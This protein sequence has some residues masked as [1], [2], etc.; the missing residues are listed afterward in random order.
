MS[1]GWR[2]GAAR[3][4]AI[5]GAL[6]AA[7]GCAGAGDGGPAA[8]PVSLREVDRA[9]YDA[10]LAE[11]R[12]QVVL[13]D[14]WA[15]WCAPC[16]TQLT[17]TLQLAERHKARGLAVITLSMDEAEAQPR[18]QK[19]LTDRASPAGV[20]HLISARGGGPGAMEEF[21]IGSGALPHY[22]LYD[23]TGK[24]RRTFEIDPLAEEQFTLDDID[25]AVEQLLA[26][27]QGDAA[28]DPAE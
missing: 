28:E 7:S 25:A 21:A 2:H 9:A 10:L 5:A 15:T 6:V 11:R 18:A 23:R 26:E 13:V 24:L 22:K 17:H 14:F 4:L 12:G 27:P 20:V 19:A 3:R 8:A 1:S 16:L